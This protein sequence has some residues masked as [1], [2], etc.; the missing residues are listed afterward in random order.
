MK[1]RYNRRSRSRSRSTSQTRNRI[2]GRNSEKYYIQERNKPIPSSRYYKGYD[3]NTKERR[4]LLIEPNKKYEESKNKVSINNQ[5]SS[6]NNLKELNNKEEVRRNNEIMKERQRRAQMLIQSL[7]KESNIKEEEDNKSITKDSC[8]LEN[9]DNI[10]K[11]S[12]NDT[13]SNKSNGSNISN[14][15]ENNIIKEYHLNETSYN[16]NYPQLNQD[17]NED[18]DEDD[19]INNNSPLNSNDNQIEEWKRRLDKYKNKQILQIDHRNIE[20][21]PIEKNIYKESSDVSCLSEVEVD[22]IRKINGNISII[23]YNHTHTSIRPILNWYQ[24]GLPKVIIDY[25]INIKKFPYPLP[26][27]SQGIPCILSGRDVIGVS[28]TGS[29]KTL[30]YVLSLIK[31]ILH[32]IGLYPF[33]FNDG[34]IGMIIVPTRELALQIY[35]ESTVYCDLVNIQVSVVYGGVPSHTQLSRIKRGS[36][37]LICTPGRMIDILSMNKSTFLSLNRL[38]FIVIDEAD[39]VFDLGFEPQIKKILLNLRPDRQIVM[40]SATFHQEVEKIGKGLMSKENKPLMIVCGKKGMTSK[41]VV[42]VIEVVDERNRFTRLLEVLYEI[43]YK[44]D[45]LYMKCKEKKEDYDKKNEEEREEGNLFD[46]EIDNEVNEDESK[47]KETNNNNDND[48][49]SIDSNKD[50][51]LDDFLNEI[52][53]IEYKE[54]IQNNNKNEENISKTTVHQ[55]QELTIYSNKDKD[56]DLSQQRKESSHESKIIIFVET[57]SEADELFI[58]LLKKGYSSL[59][60]HSG[61]SQ[62]ERF[63]YIENFRVGFRSILISTSIMSRGID[64]PDIEYVINFKCP[65]HFEDYI[66]KVG[67]TGRGGRKG[68]AITFISNQEEHLSESLVKALEVSSQK[69]PYELK[70]MFEGYRSKIEK[71]EVLYKKHNIREGRGFKFNSIESDNRGIYMLKEREDEENIGDTVDK[72]ALSIGNIENNNQYIEKRLNKLKN[73]KLKT[74]LLHIGQQTAKNCMLN[75]GTIEEAYNKSIERMVLSLKNY[76]G[77]MS[78]ENRLKKINQIYEKW[79]REEKEEEEG[80]SNKDKHLTIEFD[81]NDYPEKV[82]LYCSSKKFKEYIREVTGC[83]YE[84]RGEYMR[85][86][87]S[88]KLGVKRL[89]LKIKGQSQI[90][91]ELAFREIKKNLDEFAMNEV[92]NMMK[93]KKKY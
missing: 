24:S 66:H 61:Q 28:E 86:S 64:I 27:Q 32:N 4:Q 13:K 80:G 81:I 84:I 59:V 87:K 88:Y 34:P 75:E 23:E 67:R 68:V 25:I 42:Q 37:I 26:I 89:H 16:K 1:D 60:V 14:L 9:K 29:G 69:I 78:M 36:H 39:R 83:V 92:E 44:N 49:I 31:S 52:N 3:S 20:Y 19:D 6:N 70:M 93:N 33:S 21:T 43:D 62:Q 47:E 48:L 91:L 46:M 57:K 38:S 8:C 45:V 72:Q 82:R 76:S 51:D 63:E 58:N 40:F 18:E 41:D 77:Q 53:K 17:D 65:S 54:D 90:D 35:N 50:K 12:V 55:S 7:K 15:L 11:Q 5:L 56:K 30:T 74:H 85:S 73:D 22:Q 71:G 79:E 10:I 2:K